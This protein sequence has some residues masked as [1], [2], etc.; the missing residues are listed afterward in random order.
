MMS[1]LFS[2][3]STALTG[4][5]EGYAFLDR[6]SDRRRMLELA[7]ARV[8]QHN[9][10]GTPRTLVVVKSPKDIR[11]LLSRARV[12]SAVVVADCALEKCGSESELL[13]CWRA[14]NRAAGG[15]PGLHKG[16][17]FVLRIQQWA[18]TRLALDPRI[19]WVITCAP[20][21]AKAMGRIQY[22]PYGRRS[23]VLADTRMARR[24]KKVTP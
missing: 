2:P 21:D 23:T 3:L 4:A 24:A 6:A 17:I 16:D 7:Q 5:V 10:T 15:T 12:G 18:S 11:L 19:R 13:D 14:I 20:P 8:E 9:Q 22:R 1:F